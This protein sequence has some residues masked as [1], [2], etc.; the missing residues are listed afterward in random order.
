MSSGTGMR[1]SYNGIFL[2]VLASSG[3][4]RCRRITEKLDDPKR[5][6]TV[7]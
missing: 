1:F 3:R 5:Y 7:M 4:C 6:Q 2:E